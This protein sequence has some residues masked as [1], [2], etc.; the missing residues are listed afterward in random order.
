CRA[1]QLRHASHHE[2]SAEYA[3]AAVHGRCTL[4]VRRAAQC[5]RRAGEHLGQS[6]QS[7][8]RRI[9]TETRRHTG[10]I[11]SELRVYFLGREGGQRWICSIITRRFAKWKLVSPVSS[12]WW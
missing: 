10:E 1:G 6:S 8:V 12:P 4:R 9:D 7:T 3:G 11:L 5:G 2:L